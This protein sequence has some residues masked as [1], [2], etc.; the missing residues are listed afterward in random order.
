MLS[1]AFSTVLSAESHWQTSLHSVIEP[2]KRKITNSRKH[3]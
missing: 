1:E 2:G 3:D